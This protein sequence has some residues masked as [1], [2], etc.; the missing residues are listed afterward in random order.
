MA[1]GRSDEVLNVG[2]ALVSSALVD[3][4]PVLV[5]DCSDEGED[6]LEPE[7]AE[8]HPEGVEVPAEDPGGREDA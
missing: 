7:T 8:A 4:S 5:L 2:L 6:T 1:V 3:G